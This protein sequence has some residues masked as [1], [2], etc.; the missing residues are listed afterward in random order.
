MALANKADCSDFFLPVNP[1]C[2][3]TT[4]TSSSSTT[5]TSTTSS[6]TTTTTS[7]YP[8]VTTTTTTTISPS[9]Y[10]LL[11]NWFAASNPLLAPVG[12]R[13]TTDSDWT[14]LFSSLGSTTVPMKS[15]GN[16]TDGTGLWLKASNP[17]MEGT[18]TSGFKINPSGVVGNTGVMSGRHAYA[19]FW[20]SGSRSLT[21]GD[22]RNFGYNG[23]TMYSSPIHY[24]KNY[25]FDIRL[26]TD[27]TSG[28]TPGSTGTLIDID[29][30]IYPTKMMP[31]GKV[32]MT[33]NLRTSRYTNGVYIPVDPIDWSTT[34]IGAI[35]TYT[36]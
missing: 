18:N 5:T 12:W 7:D 30:N 1:N 23:N 6:T 3:T 24:L 22:Y 4:T 34:I 16:M 14:G 11:Y 26:V 35:H 9:I 20:G 28:Y 15:I 25:G 32:W 31:D 8:I 10:G 27:N 29:G 33:E 21:L 19:N 17:A 2:T 13:V 36:L